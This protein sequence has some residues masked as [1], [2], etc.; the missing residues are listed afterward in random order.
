MKKLIIVLVALIMIVAA[1]AQIERIDTLIN[2]NHG[3]GY[4]YI[5]INN[6][7]ED[8]FRVYNSSGTYG[9][10][11]L[12]GI[13]GANILIDSS[14]H[15]GTS[16]ALEINCND[17]ID[18]Q[19]TWV[20]SGLIRRNISST[21]VDIP[22]GAY[23]VP[24]RLFLLDTNSFTYNYKYGV[25]K[26]A[27]ISNNN[28]IIGGYYINNTWNEPFPCGYSE[29]DTAQT[30]IICTHYDT[31]AVYDTLPIYDTIIIPDTNVL[32]VYDTLT[33]YD[34]IVTHIYDTVIFIDTVLTNIYDT[35]IVYDTIE[36]FTN[37]GINE[38]EE[39]YGSFVFYNMRGEILDSGNLPLNQILIKAYQNGRRKRVFLIRRE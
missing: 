3:S 36:C 11:V 28:I 39:E 10:S 30:E 29:L 37:I 27:V 1:N 23:R 13:N 32:T 8:D 25:I 26:L 9:H 16:Y 38:T 7:G 31:I 6:D 33:I 24:F 14:N 22:Q 12:Q 2:I 20:I 18:N 19:K 4:T 17:S 34:T 21:F 15:T 35:I 5:D